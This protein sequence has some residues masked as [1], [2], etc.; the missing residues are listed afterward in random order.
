MGNRTIAFSDSLIAFYLLSI[1]THA[2]GATNSPFSISYLK[3][4]DSGR[5]V[6]ETHQVMH[7]V[8]SGLDA[9]I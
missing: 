4:S 1:D 6:F 2:E 3:T 8:I 5:A 7:D 9:I